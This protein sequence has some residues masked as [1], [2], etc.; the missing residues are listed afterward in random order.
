[1]QVFPVIVVPVVDDHL[2]HSK[3]LTKLVQASEASLSLRDH[4]L[5]SDL[6][7][8][9]CSRFD[10]P[11]SL[12]ERIRLRSILLRLQSRSPSHETRSAFPADCPHH[13]DFHCTYP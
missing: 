7:T 12:V 9:L 5:V 10:P 6:V 3:E 8:G 4:E 11:D 1:V 2:S 13:P